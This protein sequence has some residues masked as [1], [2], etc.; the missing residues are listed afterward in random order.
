MKRYYQFK[1]ECLVLCTAKSF[2]QMDMGLAWM[3]TN[4]LLIMVLSF[5]LR[6]IMA[7]AE[8]CYR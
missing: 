6:W 1:R 7:L 2:L 3:L 8:K 5:L 4:G